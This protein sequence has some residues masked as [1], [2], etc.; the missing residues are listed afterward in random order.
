MYSTATTI[1]GVR[2]LTDSTSQVQ[3]KKEHSVTPRAILTQD[4]PPTASRGS[5]RWTDSEFLFPGSGGNHPGA[6]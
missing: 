2:P 3:T 6:V 5:Q 1:A 4:S